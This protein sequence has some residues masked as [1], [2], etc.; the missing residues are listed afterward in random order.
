MMLEPIP[1]TRLDKCPEER[2]RL[3]RFGFE[4]GV[5]LAA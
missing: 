4:F 5:E 2:V 1:I 3:K